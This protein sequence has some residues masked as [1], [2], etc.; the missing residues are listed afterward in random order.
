MALTFDDGPD[1]V[2]TPRLLDELARRGVPATFF[3]VGE[4]VRA[5][6]EIVRRMVAEGHTVG[7]HSAS[8]RYSSTLAFRDRVADFR[9]GR[10]AL[11]AVLGRRVRLFRPPHGDI[12]L[13]T[14]IAIRVAGLRPWLWTADPGDWKSDVDAATIVEE[15]ASVRDRDVVLLHDGLFNA[16][17]PE[18]SDRSATIAAVDGLVEALRERGLQPVALAAC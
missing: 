10:R 1:P 11:E 9:D 13:L 8:H 15:L 2:H 3:C 17:A 4:A 12:D 6:P 14:A 18:A 16:V 7:S 5:H